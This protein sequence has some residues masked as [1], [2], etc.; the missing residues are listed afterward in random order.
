MEKS[1]KSNELSG[2]ALS[3]ELVGIKNLKSTHIWRLEFDVHEIDSHKVKHLFD[4]IDEPL[5]IG[6][7]KENA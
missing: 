5:V 1:E 2:T 4:C 3:V 6:I 7:V